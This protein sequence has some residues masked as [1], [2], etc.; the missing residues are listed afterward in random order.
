MVTWFPLPTSLLPDKPNKMM[1][2]SQNLSLPWYKDPS[3]TFADD[4]LFAKGATDDEIFFEIPELDSCK[5]DNYDGFST[6]TSV[7]PFV[8]NC[9]YATTHHMIS[10]SSSIYTILPD[11]YTINLLVCYCMNG[12]YGRSY[13]E[14]VN[15]LTRFFLFNPYVVTMKTIGDTNQFGGSNQRLQMRQSHKFFH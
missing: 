15:K 9:V 12:L 11:A 10:R 8:P 2:L 5:F 3:V 7:V 6:C 1:Y 14:D 13:P 4:L